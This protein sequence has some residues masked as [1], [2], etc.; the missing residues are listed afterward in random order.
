MA[1][2]IL[3]MQIKQSIKDFVCITDKG[4][5]FKDSVKSRLGYRIL[6]RRVL[7]EH[8]FYSREDQNVSQISRREFPRQY[9]KSL[10]LRMKSSS[11][12]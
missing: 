8:I 11:L 6:C 4:K 12:Q 5:R 9:C 1:A 2:Q 10:S 7:G 3:K